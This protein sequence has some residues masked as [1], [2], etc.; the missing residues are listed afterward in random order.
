MAMQALLVQMVNRMVAASLASLRAALLSMG[1]SMEQL[2]VAF[3]RSRVVGPKTKPRAALRSGR[4]ILRDRR[5]AVRLKPLRAALKLRSGNDWV[6]F[7]EATKRRMQVILELGDRL[8]AVT[9][10]VPYVGAAETYWGVLKRLPRSSQ[11]SGYT[12]ALAV[13][14]VGPRTDSF[15]S[16]AVWARPQGAKVREFD[17]DRHALYVRPKKSFAAPVSKAARILHKFSPWTMET[18][19][20]SP[21][22]NEAVVVLRRVSKRE[23]ANITKQ[24]LKDRPEWSKQLA[25][26]GHRQVREDRS[27]V[28]LRTGVVRDLAF[29]ALRLEFG[30]GGVKPVPHWRPALA[31]AAQVVRRLFS[32]QSVVSAALTRPNY[33]A[34]KKWAPR[35]ESSI[36]I[37]DLKSIRKFQ[38]QLK[39]RVDS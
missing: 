27:P 30:Y 23:I 4:S 25:A 37:S 2:A 7:D 17:A 32:T 6:A 26:V 31:D 15:S 24:R 1:S 10:L 11:W 3:S 13:V 28:E 35:T 8:A 22:K 21:K 19:P 39:I 5:S 38:K 9:R 29:D 14:R 36:K 16:F 12:K 33:S 34:W 20:F 18:L